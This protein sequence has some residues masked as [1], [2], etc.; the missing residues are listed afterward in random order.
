MKR[1][2]IFKI[3]AVGGVSIFMAMLVGA[4]FID[5]TKAEMLTPLAVGIVG[6]LG[7]RD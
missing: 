2:T 1:N 6:Y 5:F 7:W 4:L 3:M